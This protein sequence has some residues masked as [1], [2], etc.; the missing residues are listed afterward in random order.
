MW[1]VYKRKMIPKIK[2]EKVGYNSSLYCQE[3]G[4]LV[5]SCDCIECGAGVD[6]MDIATILTQGGGGPVYPLPKIIDLLVHPKLN[7]ASLLFEVR[8]QSLGYLFVMVISLLYCLPYTTIGQCF[9]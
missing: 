1:M 2:L 9:S 5:L 3:G 6:P 7:L 4:L 8:I